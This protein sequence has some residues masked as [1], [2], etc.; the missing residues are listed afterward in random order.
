M[1]HCVFYWI[2]ILLFIFL[3]NALLRLYK[4]GFRK[5][6]SCEIGYLQKTSGFS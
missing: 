4:Q 5:L 1:K 2:Y 6:V 3:Q